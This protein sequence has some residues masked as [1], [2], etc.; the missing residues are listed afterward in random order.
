MVNR[1]WR[2]RGIVATVLASRPKPPPFQPPA[3]P[4][5]PVLPPGPAPA[6]DDGVMDDSKL[7]GFGGGL[8]PPGDDDSKLAANDGGL[9]PPGDDDSELAGLGGGLMPP[10]EY[11]SELAVA[12]REL[13]RR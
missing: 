4:A 3:S 13:I 5:E 6:G 9:M 10:G 7:A 2:W 12:M 1:M 11:D 8:L